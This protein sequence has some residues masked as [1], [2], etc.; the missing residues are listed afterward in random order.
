MGRSLIIWACVAV[1]LAAI[2]I[3]MGWVC[4]GPVVPSGALVAVQGATR[5]EVLHILGPP[6]D[7]A[8]DGAL[9]YTRRGNYGW[10]VISFDDD[11]RVSS[12]GD[13][14]VFRAGEFRGWPHRSR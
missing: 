10:V 5:A 11:D 14:S 6:T 7:V 4:F 1:T 12:I 2:T 8:A 3:G 9:I 13:E